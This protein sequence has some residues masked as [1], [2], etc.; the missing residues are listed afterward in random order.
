MLYGRC[1]HI[2]ARAAST[3][4]IQVGD[5]RDPHHQPDMDEFTKYWLAIWK[6]QTKLGIAVTT[7]TP[8]YGPAPYCPVKPFTHGEQVSNL[9]EICDH[10]TQ[11]L[12]KL[13][14]ELIN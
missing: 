1:L 14:N 8:E 13:F 6:K 2:H 12:A 9:D 10:E 7:V 3:Q 4:Q 11:R 5:T